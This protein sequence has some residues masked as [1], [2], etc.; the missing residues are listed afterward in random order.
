MRKTIM[1]VAVLCSVVA[2]S[3]QGAR[4]ATQVI[5]GAAGAL[6]GKQRIQALKTIKLEG[7]GQIAY[8]N[9]GGNISSSPDA[10]Q[11][12]IDVPEYEKIIDLE[13]RRMRVR[14]RQHNHFVFASVE[15]V[16]GRNVAVQALD[17]Q[18]AYNVGADG[19]ATRAGA[20]AAA[21]RRIDML[22]HPIVLVRTILDQRARV[23]NLRSQGGLDLLDVVTSETDRFI[24]AVDR[25]SQLPSWISW[26]VRN[27]NLGDLTYRLHFTGY[28]PVK[29]VMLPN[30]MNTVID[31]RNISQN[32]L[33]VDAN[34]VD[35]PI[36]DLAAPADVRAAAAAAAPA[37]P[38][39]DATPV[40]KGTWLLSGRGGANSI[41]FEFADHL[42]LFELP[43]S[44]AWA[45]ALIEKA[46]SVVSGKRVTEVIVSHH[47]F[48]HTGGLRQAMASGLTIIA[49]NGV[50]GLF[51]EIA[52]RK[53]TVDPDAIGATPKPL[54]FRGVDN[55]LQLKDPLMTVDVYHTVSNSHMAEG[56]FA[57]VPQDRLLV[58]G[59]F[60]DVSWEI[61][62][63]QD[64]YMDNVRY[65]NLQVER[66]VPVHGRV[67]TLQE[68]LD[69]IRRQTRAAQDL[70]AKMAA[71]Q[72]FLP[73][74]PVKTPASVQ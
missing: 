21:A 45:R 53:S 17:G 47:H 64:T 37:A 33:Y 26:V 30:G 58:Q 43:S 20:A 59:D 10:P 48:D 19:R 56:V 28:L 51:R 22:A 3:G 16:L 5:D 60:Y 68:V 38:V 69:G 54:K 40:A 6:G 42:T 32:K 27:E 9:G 4:T 24:M 57:Y 49:H 13:N 18:I 34:T 36:P 14:Q 55:H 62:W 15:G 71:A 61:Y 65:R 63:W 29:G 1:V 72:S 35:G 66:D 7:Y 8:M 74:C 52:A 67:Q 39:V 31:F 46:Q 23:S 2:L 12:W 50:E 73:G 11:K 44:Q 41:L 70:C 25:A